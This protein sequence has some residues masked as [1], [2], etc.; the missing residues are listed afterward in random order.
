[1]Q[2]L[3]RELAVDRARTARTALAGER[4]RTRLFTQSA[5]ALEEA[6]AVLHHTAAAGLGKPGDRSTSTPPGSRTPPRGRARR[7]HH[8]RPPGALT[9]RRR[10]DE[11]RPSRELPRRDGARHEVLVRQTRDGW[12]VLDRDAAGARARVIETLESPDDDRP[13][14]EAIAHDYLANLE[15][16]Q[17][18]AGRGPA[19]AISEQGARDER[20]HRRPRTGSRKQPA[21]KAALPGSGSLTGAC[22]RATRARNATGRCSSGCCASRPPGLV[23]LAAGGRARGAAARDQAPTSRSLPRQAALPVSRARSRSCSG[24]ARGTPRAAEEV[25]VG[26]AARS[27]PRGEE[28][29]VSESRS[30]GSTSTSRASTRLG[31]PAERPCPC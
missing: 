7:R 21:R 1:M 5:A 27:A 18:R 13:Q 22:S 23:E 6:A 30:C 31:L 16:S 17:Q 20:S 11:T 8:P 14:A 15:S 9:K 29:A 25:F 2:D 4:D 3:Y 10:N 19:E 28:A 24:S 26:P 12:Q